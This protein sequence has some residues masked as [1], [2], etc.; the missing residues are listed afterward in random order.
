[1]LGADEFHRAHPLDELLAGAEP[2]SSIDDLLIDELSD[3]EADA[4]VAAIGT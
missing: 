3:D 4:F 2:L 1:V